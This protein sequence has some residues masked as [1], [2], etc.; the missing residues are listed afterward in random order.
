MKIEAS[1]KRPPKFQ[2]PGERL[3]LFRVSGTAFVPVECA[4]VVRAYNKIDAENQAH[5][6]WH[7]GFKNRHEWVVPGTVDERHPEQWNSFA[8]PLDN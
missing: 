7:D 1:P 3:Q 2:R 4:M 6:V 8:E 5:Q